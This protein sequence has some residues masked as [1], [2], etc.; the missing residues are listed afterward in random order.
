MNEKIVK[1]IKSRSFVAVGLL[2]RGVADS[3]SHRV[4]RHGYVDG[5]SRRSFQTHK[6]ASHRGVYFVLQGG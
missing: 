1:T 5:S 6:F 4:R 3:E 2:N